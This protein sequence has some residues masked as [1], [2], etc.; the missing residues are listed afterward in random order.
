M[1]LAPER[2]RR[3][4][5][6]TR[7]VR[8]KPTASVVEASGTASKPLQSGHLQPMHLVSTI[9]TAMFRNGSRIVIT[10]TMTEHRQTARRGLRAAIVLPASSVAVAETTVRSTSAPPAGAG[11]PRSFSPTASGSGSLG[12][13]PLNFFTSWVQG[14]TPVKF[15]GAE[16]GRRAVEVEHA[17]GGWR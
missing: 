5:G 15:Q 7:S 16:N 10:P 14:E 9:C 6:A 3:I 2:R 17:R 11:A 1:P 4:H 12:R 8:A 13:L